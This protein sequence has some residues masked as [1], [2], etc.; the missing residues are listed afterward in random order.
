MS[1]FSELK[2]RNVFRVAIAYLAAAWLMTEVAGTIFPIFG[3]GD[4]PARI[5]IILL[6]IGFPLF[7][8]FSWVFEL[9]PKG[10]KFEKDVSREDSTTTKTG[11][12]LD[13]VIIILLA[14]A[15]GY[16]AFDKF[17]LEPERVADIVEETVQQARSDALLK[18]YGDDSIAV[19][20]FVNMSPDPEQEFFSDGIS[21]EL[22]NLLAQIRELRVISRSSAFFYKDKDLKL[23]EIA[24]ELNVTHIL[25][26]SVRKADDRV[27]ITAQLIDARSDTHLW[28]QTYD[29][30]FDNIF[31]I[32]DEIATEVV[33][34]LKVKLLGA[35]LS[36]S[37]ID[38][39]AYAF[40]LQA[41]HLGRQ[42]TPEGLEQSNTLYR[43]AL[44]ID[45]NYAAAWVGLA[46]NYSQQVG[47]ALRPGEDIYKAREFAE[48]ALAIDPDHAA[49][50]ARLGYV[51][52]S[53]MGELSTVALHYERALALKPANT[54]ILLD[55][56][57]FVK[58]LGRLD[59][60][61]AIQEY[62]IARD[63]VNPKGHYCLG[64]TY[65]WS[66]HPD[67]AFD[68]L[69]TALTLS[70]KMVVAWFMTGETLLER[71]EPEA[72]LAAMQQEPHEGWRLSGLVLA[73]H[74]LGQA[75]ES[76]AALAELTEKYGQY[77]P[78]KIACFHAYR[79]EAD[80][81]F[82]WLDKAV[83]Y[84]DGGLAEL[85]VEALCT[86]LRNDPRWLPFLER[87]GKSPEQLAAV[88]FSVTMAE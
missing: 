26:G 9:T 85:P 63:P 78:A 43:Q 59:E 31:A 46:D 25:E 84:E 75:A 52:E 37:E 18:S 17:V 11:K 44:E 21:E 13:R 32:Q 27:R 28:S 36:T 66:G 79:G 62:A 53:T 39:E 77:A 5:V 57:N 45:P 55:A 47:K 87:I 82:E 81:A 40:Y 30:T 2:R 38:P 6:A 49:A 19:L 86:S 15:L 51:T 67:K 33:A 64:V 29:R 10:L 56:A 35:P 16:F 80:R 23:T 65:A 88:E 58:R 83:E 72:A 60:A 12:T 54:D 70:P 8:V 73:H 42:E 61:I 1:L 48:K 68:S 76:D 20:P 7:L 34:Q 3:L 22:L 69:E 41:R 74:D 14:L 24:R 4:T 71:G 50:H